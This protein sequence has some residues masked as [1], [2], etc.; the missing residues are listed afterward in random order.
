MSTDQYEC[1]VKGRLPNTRGKEDPAK[2]YSGGTLFNDHASSQIQVYH[3][4]SLGLS[5]TIRSKEQYELEGE[6]SGVKTLSYRGD[7]RVYKSKE[8]KNYLAKRGQTMSY[9]GVGVHQ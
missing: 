4:V 9:S 1:R 7:N 2:M 3:Q 5:D 8:L 6:A